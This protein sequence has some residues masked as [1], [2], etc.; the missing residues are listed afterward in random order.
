MSAG[1]KVRECF[2][3]N[4]A[5]HL[6]KHGCEQ[7]DMLRAYQKPLDIQ[8]PLLVFES[9]WL[10]CV[11]S[12]LQ[13]SFYALDSMASLRFM[14]DNTA[15]VIYDKVYDPEVQDCPFERVGMSRIYRR[16]WPLSNASQTSL[17]PS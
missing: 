12:M 14:R 17:E 15:A 10:D 11:S 6:Q 9:T 5:R 8:E 2:H 7:D 13:K 3:A 4:G 16:R 1:F